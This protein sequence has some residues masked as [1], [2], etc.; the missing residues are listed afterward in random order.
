MSDAWYFIDG[1][2]QVGPLTV[3][4]LTAALNLYPNLSGVPASKI[5]QGLAT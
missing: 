2:E 4:E 1:E 5:G 3:E